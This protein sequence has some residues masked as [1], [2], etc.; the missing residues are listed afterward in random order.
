MPT[1]NLKIKEKDNA[2][3]EEISKREEFIEAVIA[4]YI[5]GSQES[6]EEIRRLLKNI[7]AEDAF[8]WTVEAGI[9]LYKR[10]TDKK[11]FE[12]KYGIKI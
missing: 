12:K 11:A 2:P 5:I 8:M 9:V 1:V 3:K 6:H 10:V 4:V 7:G